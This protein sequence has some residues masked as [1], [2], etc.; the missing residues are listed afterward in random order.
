M[1]AGAVLRTLAPLGRALRSPSGAVGAP[2][3]LVVLVAGLGAPLLAPHDPL[4]TR[5]TQE[6][7][8][9]PPSSAHP[10]GTDNLGRDILSR[11]LH[12]LGT[13][14]AMAFG[15]VGLG[16]S[17][18][19]LVGAAAALRGG[20]ADRI[21]MRLMDAL[22]AFPVLVLAIAIS[23]ALGR[24]AWGV[25]LA[26]GFVNL[27]IFARLARGQTLRV[28]VTAYMTAARIMGCGFLRQLFVHVL[29]N[30]LN[31][32]VVQASV[33]LSFAVLIEAGLSFLGLGIQPPQPALG[34]MIA[35]AKAYLAFAPH[36]VLF[37]SL[38]IVVAVMALN[39]LGDA[40]AEAGGPGRD[41]GP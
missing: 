38:A 14:M 32:I 41:R 2:L 31:P 26:V 21:A 5:L 20:W 17:L 22:L 12:G 39:L 34:L 3:L 10:F 25:I 13:S 8:F 24:G 7:L 30:V 36:M 29:P 27:P 6:G 15:A 35:E 23:V 19:T 40:M 9:Q 18:G 33:S 4:L 16:V 37:P 28:N 11:T 1:S